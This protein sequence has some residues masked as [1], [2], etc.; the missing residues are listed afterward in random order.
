[1]S[2]RFDGCSL[3]EGISGV[4]YGGTCSLVI[5]VPPLARLAVGMCFGM[6]W[7]GRDSMR[8]A[9]RTFVGSQHFLMQCDR[10]FLT[11]TT[12]TFGRSSSM[13]QNAKCNIAI[14]DCIVIASLIVLLQLLLHPWPRDFSGS[15][16]ASSPFH[17]PRCDRSTDRLEFHR[18]K[19]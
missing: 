8:Y 18:P 2:G 6:C 5:V 9:T 12:S 16:W 7:A 14:I 19:R 10:V 17:A 15:A 4:P 3:I 1:M 11:K 13:Q